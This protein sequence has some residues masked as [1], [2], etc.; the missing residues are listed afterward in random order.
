MYLPSP[1]QCIGRNH[2]LTGRPKNCWCDSPSRLEILCDRCTWICFDK[3]LF[4]WREEVLYR[5]YLHDADD[6]EFSN[7]MHLA[8][9][10]ILD[11]THSGLDVQCNIYCKFWSLK[12]DGKYLTSDDVKSCQKFNFNAL[13]I[14]QGHKFTYRG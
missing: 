6:F 12:F 8:G 2:N 1:R 13:S 14:L 10:E 7:Q 11:E 3:S 9:T 4:I 5:I